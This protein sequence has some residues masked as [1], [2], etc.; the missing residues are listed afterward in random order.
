[1]YDAVYHPFRSPSSSDNADIATDAVLLSLEA[2]GVE[3]ISLSTVARSEGR[4][5]SALHHRH[6]SRAQFLEV[7]VG[8]FCRRW[9]QWVHGA[10]F[11]GSLPIRLPEGDDE[12]LGMRAWPMICAVAEGE[13]RAGRPAC[14]ELVADVRRDERLH[15]R[16]CLRARRA[17]RLPP[18]DHHLEVVMSLAEGIRASIADPDRGVTLTE[19][20]AILTETIQQ[21][22]GVALEPHVSWPEP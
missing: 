13:R 1:M 21:L 14:A 17:D 8:R 7:V 6:G 16:D 20:R 9:I 10:G 2:G 5:A 22:L 4:T 18:S 15:V 3:Q 19:G 11:A 12:L